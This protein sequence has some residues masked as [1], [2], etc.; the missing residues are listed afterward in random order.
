MARKLRIEYSVGFY[1]LNC[2]RRG[3]TV[4]HDDRELF[5][6]T[7]AQ[8]CARAGWQVHAYCLVGNHSD[9]VLETPKGN[10]VAGLN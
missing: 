7:L 3:E 2:G 5:L 8:G 9:R 10:L 4:F 1:H 6:A